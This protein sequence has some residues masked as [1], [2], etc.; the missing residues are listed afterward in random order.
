MRVYGKHHTMGRKGTPEDPANCIAEVE[1]PLSK[2][3]YQ[4]TRK[5]GHGHNGNFCKQHGKLLEQN[6][7]TVFVPKDV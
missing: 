2:R 1:C 7:N 6:Y 3:F 4:C 5:R